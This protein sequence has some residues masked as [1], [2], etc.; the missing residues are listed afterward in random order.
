MK[1]SLLKKYHSL[2][3]TRPLV[4]GTLIGPRIGNQLKMARAASVDVIEFRVDTFPHISQAKDLVQKIKKKTKLPILLTFRSHKESGRSVL[5]QRKYNDG[6]RWN[7]IQGILPWVEAVDVEAAS[8]PLLKKVAAL[9]S[10][11]GFSVIA[12]HHNFEKLTPIATLEGIRRQAV[13]SGGDIFKAAV[14]P[15]T[16]K[17]LRSFLRWGAS[18]RQPRIVLIGMGPVGFIS[19]IAGYT[20]GSILTF[21]HLGESAAPGQIPAKQLSA[22]I[23]S[24]YGTR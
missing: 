18:V 4:V 21:G 12:S 15:K 16:E 23:R 9:K 19:R 2:L 8:A 10:R 13:S 20:F 14:M 7:I 3:R 17:E 22:S 11:E 1:P 5:S 6:V 24:I